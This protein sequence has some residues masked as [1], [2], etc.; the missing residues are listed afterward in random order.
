MLMVEPVLLF[1]Y[2]QPLHRKSHPRMKFKCRNRP[3]W[4]IK[5]R[6]RRRKVQYCLA[7]RCRRRV[8]QRPLQLNGRSFR[9]PLSNRHR[10]WKQAKRKSRQRWKRRCLRNFLIPATDGK[11]VLRESLPLESVEHFCDGSRDFLQ[12][13]RLLRNQ[14]NLISEA[15]QVVA[16]ATVLR[17]VMESSPFYR[18][19]HN[20]RSMP[21]VWDTGASFGLTPYRS[22]FMDYV[23][24]NIPV[25]DVSKTN[26]VIGIGTTLHKFIDTNGQV[27]FLPCISYHLPS[28]DIRLF[29]PQTYH[30][31]HGGHS[32]VDGDKVIMH[33]DQ[34]CIEILIDRNK[35]NL[36]ILDN[37]AVT[38]KEKRKA[39]PF[40]RSALAATEA[41][42]VDIFGDFLT[43]S[44]FD[45]NPDVDAEYQYYSK[46]CCPCVGT[47]DNINLSA[48]QRELLLWHWRLGIS[49]RRVQELMTSHLGVDPYGVKKYFP[50]IIHPKYRSASSC[51]IPACQSC[52]IARAKRRS[53]GV[54]QQ[55]P[56]V[57]KQGA[58]SRDRYE[59]GDFVSTDQYVVRTPGRLP[60]GYGREAAEKRFHG[61]TIFRDA[62]TGIIWIENQVSLGANET[63]MAKVKFEEWL[64]DLAAVEIRHF[65]SDNGI[66]TADEF[67]ADCSRKDQ[68]QSFSGVGAQH[69]NAAAERA[70]RTI[71]EMARSFLVHTSLHWTENGTD[72]LCLWPFAMKH[73]AWLYNRVPRD[74]CGLTPIELLTKTKSDHK[75]LLRSHVWGC[76]TYVLDPTLQDGK[77]LPKWNRRARL[78]QFLGFSEAHSSLVANIRNLT[79][80]FVSPQYHVVYDDLFETIFASNDHDKELIDLICN[81]L[82]E[83]NRDRFIDD[84]ND[85]D[86]EIIYSTPPL[87]DMWIDEPTQRTKRD[88]LRRQ[89]QI[90]EERERTRWKDVTPDYDGLPAE[91]FEPVPPM[92][93][94]VSDDES[95]L[96]DDDAA[97]TAPPPYESEGEQ[98][99]LQA[100]PQPRRRRNR[101]NWGS[102]PRWQRD[103]SGR[104]RRSDLH[105]SNMTCTFGSKQVPPYAATLSRKKLHGRAR[106][107]YQR[108]KLLTADLQMNRMQM[109]DDTP[110]VDALLKSPLARFIKLAANDCGYSGSTKELI[111]NWIHPFF[112]AAKTAASKEDNPNWWQAMNG[113]FAEDY[114]KAACK[115]IET[116]ER[117]HAWDVV[118]RPPD[119]NVIDSTWAFKLK[120]YPDGLAKKFKGRFCARG[121]QQL[122][123]IDFFETYAPVVQWTTVRL[124]LILEV[125]LDLKSKQGDVTCAFLHADIPEGEQVYVEMPLG[126]RKKGMVLKLRKTLYGL[127]QSPRAF[128]QFLTEKLKICGLEQTTVDPCL[129]A[130]PTVIC[131]C[132]VDDLLFWARDPADIDRL[133]ISLIEAGVDLEEEDDA[134]G[135]LGVHM[136]KARGGTLELKQ[137]G[138]IDR[139]LT[140]LGLNDGMA[141]CKHTPS[142]SRPLTKDPDGEQAIGTFS[143]SSV[144][145]M[146]LYLAGHSRPDIAYAV[147]CCARY[148]FC[149]RLCHETALKRIGR[150]LLAT[151]TRGLIIK[152]TLVE[153]SLQIDSYPDADFAGLYGYERND[154]PACAKS[155]TGYVILVCSCPVLWQSKLQTETAL[156]TMEAEIIALAH[157][158]RELFPIMDT[159][160]CL[161]EA[162]GLPVGKT[163]LNVSIHEDNSGA[164]ILAETLPPQ[165]TPRS[166]HYA[167]KTIWFREQIVR[168]GIKLLKI[169]TTEQ[170]GD[171][172]T[173]G[174][175]RPVFEYL[176]KKLMGW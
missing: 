143:Y 104:M 51:K 103:S 25:K 21:L 42:Q 9:S 147:N 62:A 80:G 160:E 107:A 122:E 144:V 106:R 111:V 72:D 18:V 3:H 63:V 169:E 83:S 90:T 5:R 162:I 66:Y 148:M 27:V 4:K 139:I 86:G 16:R 39:S 136:E 105:S 174:L 141:K 73:A 134:A 69:Q 38:D 156:S 130:G 31:L 119:A 19:S 152:P 171:L 23:E 92:I 117:M 135:F 35:T 55:T 100:E 99:A 158:C 138:L 56:V 68:T 155:R 95:D 57:E 165:F 163:K 120:R 161:G 96:S 78:G 157:S 112:L 84:E 146:L 145:G 13:P 14:K 75:D 33:L 113:P 176:R 76:P 116:L 164:L 101:R 115:E 54:M 60:S 126:F 2:V 28:T 10:R 170:L 93:P 7:I 48:P 91:P 8:G 24:C 22:D 102:E 175:A 26:T 154:D 79:T 132:Y 64:W 12:I 52:K 89:R 109:D 129:F 172:F 44:Q 159:V 30:Q 40:I 128:W 87:D 53:P 123:G 37:T 61:G 15:K 29:S 81:D 98:P 127:R 151:R 34:H 47:E 70:I 168:R 124:M 131:I 20:R 58:L 1:R 11:F 88:N 67:K 114:W 166:K 121:D 43:S 17:S 153:G 74:D 118:P 110:T 41:R 59:P 137:D 142:E 97:S 85:S 108:E 46:L 65:H 167:T 77:K 140:A 6:F 125:L 133:A 71:T 36:P 32:T 150:Y 45:K 82:F 50:P 94:A 49:M 173:K 149:P